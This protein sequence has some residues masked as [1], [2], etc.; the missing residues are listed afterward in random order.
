M[1]DNET[2]YVGANIPPHYKEAVAQHP[3][4]TF[5]EVIELAFGAVAGGADTATELKIQHKR[6]Q[7]QRLRA[8]KADVEDHLADLEAEIA[9]VEADL[10]T[11]EDTRQQH[12]AAYE[13]HLESIESNIREGMCVFPDHG[14]VQTAASARG[15][16]VDRVIADLRERNPDLPDH[17]FTKYRESERKWTGTTGGP[18]T[19]TA[20][21][22]QAAGDD[23]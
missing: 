5:T 11:L 6:E 14:A 17:A 15:V 18:S 2:A 16:D 3:D 7:L 13:D 23:D 21:P 1:S 9:D 19:A 10:E 20:D 8:E 22:N 4:W 12:A